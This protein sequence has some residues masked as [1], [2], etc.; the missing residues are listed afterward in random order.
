MFI[1]LIRFL[2]PATDTEANLIGDFSKPY[3][4]PLVTGA[5]NSDLKSIS[6]HTM[7]RLLRGEFEDRVSSCHIIDC[8]YPYEFE[9]GHIA[10]AKNLY[11]QE[12]IV[13]ELVNRKTEEMNSGSSNSSCCVTTPACNNENID[14]SKKNDLCHH[15]KRDIL[16]FHC[17]F[18]SERGPKL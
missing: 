2:F 7:A 15:L 16:V 5:R 11:T 18:S 6:V 3:C 13:E 12:Q 8:R 14:V 1:N 17:E 10:G 9:G 4:L